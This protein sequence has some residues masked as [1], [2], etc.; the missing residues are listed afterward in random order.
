MS[1]TDSE[2]VPIIVQSYMDSEGPAA[3]AAEEKIK[4]QKEVNRKEA[5]IGASKQRG[6]YVTKNEHKVAN[7][8]NF[9]QD[10]SRCI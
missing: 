4:K 9:M 8:I 5:T 6:S 3:T 1:I 7:L 2:V 10:L